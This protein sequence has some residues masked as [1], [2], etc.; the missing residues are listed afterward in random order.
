MADGALL[1]YPRI[2]DKGGNEWQR[3]TRQLT[4]LEYKITSVKSLLVEA[5]T[6]FFFLSSFF[7]PNLESSR[8]VQTY[9]PIL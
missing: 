7:P 1:P 5:K 2:L 8:L 3:E 9:A 6:F 4:A